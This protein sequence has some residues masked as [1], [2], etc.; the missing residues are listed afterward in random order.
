MVDF[1]CLMQLIELNTWSCFV[2]VVVVDFCCHAAP[3]ALAQG[4]RVVRTLTYSVTT[5]ENSSWR[6]SS[7]YCILL[8]LLRR[9]RVSRLSLL[10][11]HSLFCLGCRHTTPSLLSLLA[12]T[13]PTHTRKTLIRCPAHFFPLSLPQTGDGR[14]HPFCSL[15]ATASVLYRDPLFSATFTCFVALYLASSCYGRAVFHTRTYTRARRETH[16]HA[17]ICKEVRE[18]HTLPIKFE[19]S[20]ILLSHVVPC[21]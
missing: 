17:H 14:L 13:I 10:P 19:G 7:L 1:G 2:V 18:K 12:F 11:T 15:G 21:W 8:L 16:K 4:H 3:I 20:I 5:G 9:F 6:C